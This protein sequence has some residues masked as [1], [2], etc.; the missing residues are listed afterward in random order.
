MYNI[1]TIYYVRLK[2]LKRLRNRRASTLEVQTSME[3]SR[4]VR[5]ASAPFK[6]QLVT[7]IDGKGKRTFRCDCNC[8]T[9]KPAWWW[10]VNSEKI[11]YTYF[12]IV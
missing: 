11:I 7:S 1:A 10:W 5:H 4:Y 2:I 3:E 6:G 12:S 9:S 8:E